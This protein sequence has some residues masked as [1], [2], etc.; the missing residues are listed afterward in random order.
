MVFIDS[1]LPATVVVSGAFAIAAIVASALTT[2][3][4]T[5][6]VAVAA[7]ALAALSALW[8]HNWGTVE[9]WIRLATTLAIGALAVP[10]AMVRVRREQSLRH[11]TAIA[12]AAQRA[13]LPAM[14]S[15][16]GSLG[17]AARYVSATHEALVGGDLY[18]VVQTPAGVRMV[19]GDARGKGLD[20]VQMAATVLAGFRQ[21]AVRE[22]SLAAVAT[23]LDHVVT[24]VAGDED[25][26][27]A[28]LAEFHEDLSVTLV[29]CG[30]PPPMLLTGKDP[31]RLV[32][33]G[34]PE[35]PLGLGPSPCPVTVDLPEGARLLFYTD[36]I[37]EG[38]DHDGDFFP[39][40]HRATALGT[41][42][43]GNALDGL[44]SDLTDHVG[45]QINDDVALVL[46][47]QQAVHHALG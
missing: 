18:E 43:L 25:F 11:M 20:A 28:L 29:N 2:V 45:H 5:A 32:D 33:T 12:E 15:S 42:R 13:L 47:E 35:P 10:L 19:V 3:R 17:F 36:G 40:A 41:G 23:D 22:P 6:A 46:V 39:L 4:R 24:S 8:N 31:G 27:T 30:H 34:A 38:R 26:V 44:L 1:L 7:F 16:I 14:P 21:A 9:W 37:M